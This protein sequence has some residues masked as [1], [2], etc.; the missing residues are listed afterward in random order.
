VDTALAVN[1]VP[2][3]S[4][5]QQGPSELA[6][7][8]YQSANDK[9]SVAE[10]CAFIECEQPKLMDLLRTGVVPG[11]KQGKAWVI[12]RLAFLSAMNNL[13]STSAVKIQVDATS[14]L[15]KAG[16]APVENKATTGTKATAAGN[17]V[18]PRLPRT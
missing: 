4:L 9:V 5:V 7:P 18:R 2:R 17:V 12:P 14:A 3:L 10:A 1:P 16:R 15:G 8:I 6:S 11:F 13:A